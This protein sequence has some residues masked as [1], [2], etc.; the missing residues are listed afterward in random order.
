MK[1]SVFEQMK[2]ENAQAH[3]PEQPKLKKLLSDEDIFKHQKADKSLFTAQFGMDKKNKVETFEQVGWSD[4]ATSNSTKAIKWLKNITFDENVYPK[5][6]INEDSPPSVVFIPEKKLLQIM[7]ETTIKCDD[8]HQL[9]AK[10]CDMEPK[11]GTIARSM[12]TIHN[13]SLSFA[14]PTA[15]SDIDVSHQTTNIEQ[16][17]LPDNLKSIE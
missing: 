12:N 8:R 9:M 4:P 7:I 14:S 17:G 15:E 5:R 3:E 10:F 16:L 11:Q 6:L 13:N 2:N 1:D